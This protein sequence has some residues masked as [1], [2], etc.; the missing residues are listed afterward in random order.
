MELVEFLHDV[1]K[2][3]ELPGVFLM[4]CLFITLVMVY[5]EL[6]L[7]TPSELQEKPVNKIVELLKLKEGING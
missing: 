4:S 7:S 1:L 6:T 3:K 5:V 2:V